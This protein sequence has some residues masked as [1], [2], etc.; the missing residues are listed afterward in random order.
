[1]G[2]IQEDGKDL[3]ASLDA[4]RQKESELLQFTQKITSKNTEL[5]SDVGLLQSKVIVIPLECLFNFFIL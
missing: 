1:M 5:H 4:S 3:E 2:N